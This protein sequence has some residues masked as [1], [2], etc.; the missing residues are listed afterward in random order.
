MI[1]YTDILLNNKKALKI[2]G[3]K[4][5]CIEKHFDNLVVYHLDN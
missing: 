4:I 2:F 3:S 1:S 5:F